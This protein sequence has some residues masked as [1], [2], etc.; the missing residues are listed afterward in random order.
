MSEQ[1]KSQARARSVPTPAR[2]GTGPQAGLWQCARALIRA[3]A[4]WR[5]L[6]SVFQ[7]WSG[8]HGVC[9]RVVGKVKGQ[10]VHS[11]HMHP[12]VLA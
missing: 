10:S 4:S 5:F 11:L 8:N 9:F 12:K 6:P 7:L 2:G 3:P 1:S